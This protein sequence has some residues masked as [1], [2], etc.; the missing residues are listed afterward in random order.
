MKR[1]KPLAARKPMARKPMGQKSAVPKTRKPAKLKKCRNTQ[2]L[3]EFAPLRLG[4]KACSIPCSIV[5]GREEEAKKLAKQLAEEAK[6]SRAERKAEKEK[7]KTIGEYAKQAQD[8]F[9][10]WVRERDYGHPCISCG[11]TACV[12]Y[13]AGHY[14]TVGACKA[15]R[16]EPLNV[17]RQCN[18]NC[19]KGKSGNITEYRIGLVKKIGAE[20]VAWLEG[21]HD[22]V[23]YRKEDYV[24]I[25]AKY[26]A[27][28]RELV[29]ARER[30]DYG[31]A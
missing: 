12:Q 23:R 22:P 13:A 28:R 10:A 20:A 14:R 8:A 7:I 17:H 15:L 1:S 27:L 18:R 30:G 19:N 24:A 25:A 2:C 29:K 4:Q 16:F 26:R 31:Q 3:A 11:T 6:K 5:V 21:P 9:N